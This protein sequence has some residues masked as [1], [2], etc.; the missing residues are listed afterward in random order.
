[1]LFRSIST[2]TKEIWYLHLDFK[3]L[4]LMAELQAQDSRGKSHGAL[5]ENGLGAGCPK[6]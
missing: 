5:V 3:E 1:M 2:R 4:G 6:P